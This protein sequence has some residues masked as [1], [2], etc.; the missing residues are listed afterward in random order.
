MKFAALGGHCYFDRKNTLRPW[1]HN[2]VKEQWFA[3]DILLDSL[4]AFGMFPQTRH[5]ENVVHRSG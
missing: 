5:V 3:I 4:P 2:F 1:S